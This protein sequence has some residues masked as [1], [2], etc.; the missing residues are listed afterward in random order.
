[1]VQKRIAVFLFAL[2]VLLLPTFAQAQA[3]IKVNDNVNIRFGALIQGWADAQQDALTQDYV[4][5][6]F[7][8]RMRIL[9]AGQIHPNVTFFF[10]TDNPN[11][12]RTPKNLSA[13]FITQDAFVEWKPTGKN[14]FIIDGGLMLPA[15]CRNCLE[16]AASLLSLDYGSF[17]FTESA[18]TQSSVGRD[19]GVQFKGYLAANKFEYRVGVFNG[20]RQAASPGNA[21]G[22]NPLRL[23]GRLSYN[24]W[25]TE[26]GYVYP[27]MYFGN[28][29]VLQIGGGLDHQQDYDALTADAFLSLPMG[30]APAAP[31]AAPGAPPPPAPNRNALNAELT[32]LGFDG[33]TTF[34]TLPEQKDITLQV[35]YYLAAPKV[36]PWIRFEKQDFE[37]SSRKGANNNRQQIGF[38]WFPYGHN[39]NTKFAYSHIDPRTGN[40][41]NEFTIQMQFFYY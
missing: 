3:I 32:I 12:G 39:F 8:R 23:T 30:A 20:F 27:G 21:A 14:S 5:Q 6:L 24:L 15:L 16:S 13:G 37:A 33:G 1:M 40:G 2:T 11:L 4:Q 26:V 38:T 36:Q 10:E 17:S 9:I 34:S 25:D 29:R 7:L 31:A 35:G 19:T 22:G 28:K 41:T 18:A